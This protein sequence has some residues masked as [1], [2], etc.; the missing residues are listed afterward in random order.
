MATPVQARPCRLFIG[1]PQR[2]VFRRRRR[3]FRDFQ[4]TGDDTFAG[5][6]ILAIALEV[7]NDMLG[8]ASSMAASTMLPSKLGVSSGNP[9]D[10]ALPDESLAR[11]IPRRRRQR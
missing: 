8:S 6:N 3:R 7:P 5:K 2:S 10:R 1:V 9:V 4:F 11:G